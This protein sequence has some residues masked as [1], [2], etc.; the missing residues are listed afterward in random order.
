[1]SD[2]LLPMPGLSASKLGG[3][4]PRHGR[5]AVPVRRGLQTYL[6]IALHLILVLAHVSLVIVIS[7]HYEHHITVETGHAANR[8][9][10]IV[11]AASQTI[12]TVR[13]QVSPNTWS[14]K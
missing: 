13:P 11:T 6:C 10:T 7:G 12:G 5:R 4:V 2:P 3:G 9:S 8:L 1:M 14:M